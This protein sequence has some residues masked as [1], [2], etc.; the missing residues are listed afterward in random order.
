MASMLMPNDSCS[1][2][3]FQRLFCTTS[4]TASFFRSMTTRMPSRSDSSRMSAMPSMR[5][6]RTSSAIFSIS[7]A[8]LTWYGISVATIE[9]RPVLGCSSTVVRARIS[10]LPRPVS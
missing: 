9:L 3:I 6:S 10:T 5:F 4:G 1:G 2:V 7:L 8:L